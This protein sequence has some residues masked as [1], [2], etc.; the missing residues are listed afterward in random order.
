LVTR[1]LNYVLTVDVE[2]YFQVEAF[3]NQVSRSDWDRYPSHVVANTRKLLDLFDEFDTKATY[4]ILGWVADK[5]P[6]LVRDIHSRGHEVACHSFWHR[7]VYSLTPEAFREDL[8]QACDAIGQACGVRP[9]GYRAPSW[10]IV[11][12]SLWALDI[13]AEEGFTYDSSIFPIQHDLYGIPGAPR[14]PYRVAS[15]RLME[16]PP[17]TV[18]TLGAN[19]PAAGGGYLRIFPMWYTEWALRRMAREDGQAAVIYLHPW[20]VDPKQM[21]IAAPWKSRFRHY[22]H[23][24]TME[25]KLRHLLGTRRFQPFRELQ[26]LPLQAL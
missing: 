11:K 10:S 9:V 18:R 1:D 14:S 23:L 26:P 21:R 25:S 12:S 2:D 20:E 19:L 4:F 7:P 15:D 6:E 3:A 16:Y 17:A 13:L 22:T 5:F 24:E 8:R